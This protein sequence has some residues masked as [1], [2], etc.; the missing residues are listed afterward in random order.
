M[1]RTG[2][3]RAGSNPQKEHVTLGRRF[4][5]L[6]KALCE[7]LVY[8]CPPTHRSPI[9]RLRDPL[10]PHRYSYVFTSGSVK[11]AHMSF[12]E[13][14]I[15]VPEGET[16]GETPERGNVQG[17]G[18]STGNPRRKVESHGVTFL[19]RLVVGQAHRSYGLNVARAAGMDEELIEL[20]ARKSGEMQDRGEQLDSPPPLPKI[21]T[22]LCF[23]S[24]ATRG[25]AHEISKL[26]SLCRFATDFSCEEG[27]ELLP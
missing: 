15:A 5:S 4:W 7:E 12:I 21:D 14:P 26:R 3:R 20:A 23:S 6:V 11:N 8:G 17:D 25:L 22:I 16:E 2:E 24:A 13:D 19:Y 1:W 10:C 27:M 9:P 18:E